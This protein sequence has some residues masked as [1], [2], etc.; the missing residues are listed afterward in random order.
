[1][2]DF[3][4]YLIGV[5]I[6]IGPLEP[7]SFDQVSLFVMLILLKKTLWNTTIEQELTYGFTKNSMTQKETQDYA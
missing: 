4:L 3:P 6:F 2:I 5:C 7:F 1:M